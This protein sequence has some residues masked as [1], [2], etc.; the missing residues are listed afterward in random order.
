LKLA[1]VVINKEPNTGLVQLL[2]FAKR[3]GFAHQIGTALPQR[4][5]E[6]FDMRRLPTFLTNGSV[7]FG[8][9]HRAIAVPQI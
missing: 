2:I 6:A 5:V 7:A 8:G 3:E 9:Q 4:V 1:I